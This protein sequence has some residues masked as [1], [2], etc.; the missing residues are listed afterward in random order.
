MKGCSTILIV[1][2]VLAMSGLITYAIV[3]SDLPLWLKIFLLR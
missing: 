1:L 2:A 3:S